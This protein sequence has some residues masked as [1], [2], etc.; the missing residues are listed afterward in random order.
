MHKYTQD[1]TYL[2][3]THNALILGHLFFTTI[4]LSLKYVKALFAGLEEF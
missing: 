3:N 1:S 2:F 4:N